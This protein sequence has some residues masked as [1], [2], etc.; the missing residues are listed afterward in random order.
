M[1]D[2]ADE[3]EF[4]LAARLRD[5]SDE[6]AQA[7][8]KQQMVADRNEDIDVIGIAEDELEAAVQVFS[9]AGAASSGARASWSTRSRTLDPGRRG[10]HRILEELYYDEP[11]LGVP[12]QVLV[13]TSNPTTS[14]LRGVAD[15]QRGIEGRDPRAP[16]WRQAPACRRR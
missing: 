12:K 3:L 6:R 15:D 9:F 13:P 2:A 16:A 4:E 10:R 8:E 1:H 11:P 7:I 5:R 14:T